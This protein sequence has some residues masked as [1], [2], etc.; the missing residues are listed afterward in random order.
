MIKKMKGIRYIP[1]ALGALL[2]ISSCQQ[3]DIQNSV[4]RTSDD[5]I[6]FSTT[7]PSLIPT[8]DGEG[9]GST[10]VPDYLLTFDKF[11][12]FRVTSLL[13]NNSDQ[14]LYF[15]DTFR[16]T[17]GVKDGKKLFTSATDHLWPRT[18][19]AFYAYYP[20]LPTLQE[21]AQGAD[22][23]DNAENAENAENTDILFSNDPDGYKLKNFTISSDMRKK[24]DF[25]TASAKWNYDDTDQ[26]A[27]KKDGTLNLNF[28]HKLCKVDFEAFSD[29]DAYDYEIIGIRLGNPAMQ[30]DFNFNAPAEE[31]QEEESSGSEGSD[32][33]DPQEE[34]CPYS[35]TKDQWENITPGRFEYV[36]KNGER[37]ATLPKKG[38]Q[39][40]ANSVSI[41]G[42]AH[43]AMVIPIKN[44]A[45][46]Y[47][48]EDGSTDIEPAPTE[49]MYISVL[50]RVTKDN[51]DLIAFPYY[52][53]VEYPYPEGA[54]KPVKQQH[55]E[56]FYNNMIYFAVDEETKE[57][58][59]RL[60]L[61]ENS[62]YKFYYYDDEGNKKD[63]L[64]P[65]HL[66]TEGFAWAAIPIN[67]DWKPGNQYSYTFD[68]SRGLGLHDPDDP[69]AGKP[70]YNVTHPTVTWGKRVKWTVKVNNWQTGTNYEPD[71]DI[72]FE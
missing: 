17:A 6:T 32:S 68:F 71:I 35:K 56:A 46:S 8:R 65:D 67:I 27:D 45:W 19:V 61:D 28:D 14:K 49:Q 42:N 52:H 29:N 26:K 60:Y 10:D 37:V 69:D 24:V 7:V 20:S 18:P 58:A 33:S 36:F 59:N 51:G 41:M 21:Y 62:I 48:Y 30:A 70:I 4:V 22:N 53:A 12:E 15:E 44:D 47:T 38:D 2:W 23:A 64:W 31:T 66:R 40:H 13:G 39:E 50:I 72:D 57:I 25:V 16:S 3:E 9:S 34:Y 63:Y 5:V 54:E 43:S 1:A 55:Y 11:N